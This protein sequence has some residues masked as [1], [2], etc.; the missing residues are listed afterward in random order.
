MT[1]FAF[2][3]AHVPSSTQC[4]DVGT[5]GSTCSATSD[6]AQ[7]DVGASMGGSRG[8]AGPG[9]HSGGD[10]GDGGWYGA[11]DDPAEAVP[12]C[13]PGFCDRGNYDVFVYPTVTA[14][15]LVSFRPV[16]PS[17]DNEPS[18][19]AVVGLP[20]NVYAAASG[21]NMVGELLGHEVAVRFVPVGFEFDYGDGTTSSSATGGAPWDAQGSPQFTPTDTGHTY[22]AR[23]T[24]IVTATVVYDASVDWGHGWRPVVGAVRAQSTGHPVEVLEAR[25]ALVERSCAESP[26]GP[27]C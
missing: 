16:G 26:R 12:D 5:W 27:G 21:Q 13:M 4:N 14:D 11:D 10:D 18:G 2:S 19:F 15:D 24:Y 20:T 22:D 8:P 3:I 6:G 9:T 23:G 1:I 7:V 25:T 17:I